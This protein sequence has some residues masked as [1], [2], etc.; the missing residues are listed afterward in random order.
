MGLQHDSGNLSQNW[1]PPLLCSYCTVP[2]YDMPQTSTAP[3][4]IYILPNL[5]VTTVLLF[6]LAIAALQRFIIDSVKEHLAQ[7]IKPPD[8]VEQQAR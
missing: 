6:S 3:R 5:I 1:I 4:G 2:W 7:I 8:A